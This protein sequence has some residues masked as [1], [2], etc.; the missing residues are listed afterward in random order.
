MREKGPG[1]ASLSTVPSPKHLSFEIVLRVLNKPMFFR[2]ARLT[3]V[4]LGQEGEI[5]DFSDLPIGACFE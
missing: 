3:A 4:S 1:T 5:P 2:L